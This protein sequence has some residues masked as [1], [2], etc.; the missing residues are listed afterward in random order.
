MSTN[1]SD[2]HE[3]YIGVG[4]NLGNRR[5]QLELAVQ[6]LR[7]IGI[8]RCSAIYETEPVGY[9]NQERFYNMVIE[10]QTHLQPRALLHRLA[11]IERHAHRDRKI[12]FGPRTLDLDILL[13][14]N[15]YLCFRDLCV[16][17]PRM[18]ER[19]F[20]LVPLSD[21]VPAR[22]GLGGATILEL[23]Q[24]TNLKEEVRYVG[25]PICSEVTRVSQAEEFN[26]S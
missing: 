10:L 1:V 5:K 24:A 11:D 25:H 14:D 23:A 7:E 2:R 4:S 15:A 9:L 12:R 26:P 8:S 16:P 3:A 20:V 17:H 13:Y 18:W 22:K 19:A 6:S 21:L